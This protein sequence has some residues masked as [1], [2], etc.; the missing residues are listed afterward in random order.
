[1]K[2]SFHYSNRDFNFR[3]FPGP[4]RIEIQPWRRFAITL[5]KTSWL[6]E[7]QFLILATTLPE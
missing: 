5:L 6:I 3:L 7:L 4:L 1:M 2:R